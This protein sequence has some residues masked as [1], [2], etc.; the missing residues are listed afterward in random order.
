M[1]HYQDIYIT[2]ILYIKHFRP[3]IIDH[4]FRANSKYISF[5][6]NINENRTPIHCNIWISEYHCITRTENSALI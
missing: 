2:K 6:M 4:P 1:A 3:A 5:F